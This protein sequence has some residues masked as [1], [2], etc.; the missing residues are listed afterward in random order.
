[1]RERGHKK[2]MRTTLYVM[3]PVLLT[4]ISSLGTRKFI[5]NRNK[6]TLNKIT[7]SFFLIIMWLLYALYYYCLNLAL[8]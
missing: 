2:I 7:F 3:I 6:S 5:D 8:N 4:M 1:M